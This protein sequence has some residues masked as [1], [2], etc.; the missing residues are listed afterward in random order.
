[1]WWPQQPSQ[2]LF[3]EGNEEVWEP[4][5]SPAQRAQSTWLRSPLQLPSPEGPSGRW[6]PVLCEPCSTA[7]AAK[8]TVAASPRVPS[9][10][11]APAITTPF[12]Q[13]CLKCPGQAGMGEFKTMAPPSPRA[14]LRITLPKQA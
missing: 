6:A 3:P 13:G 7:D 5:P 12:T 1:M 2:S 8:A 11:S 4:Q 14:E 9:M 10:P